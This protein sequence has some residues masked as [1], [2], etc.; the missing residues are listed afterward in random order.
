MSYEEE[1]QE[2]EANPLETEIDADPWGLGGLLPGVDSLGLEGDALLRQSARRRRV[3]SL[4]RVRP[5][6]VRDWLDEV[7][8]SGAVGGLSPLPFELVGQSRVSIGT[9][10]SVRLQAQAQV[11]LAGPWRLQLPPGLVVRELTFGHCSALVAPG[12]IP[13]E[14]FVESPGVSPHNCLAFDAPPLMLGCIASLFLENRGLAEVELSATLWGRTTWAVERADKRLLAQ[15]QR[16]LEKTRVETS[17]FE[18]RWLERRKRFTAE[19]QQLLGGLA[20]D[21]CPG[22]HSFAA[23][24]RFRELL[25]ELG[26]AELDAAEGAVT[27]SARALDVALD[28]FRE[29]LGSLSTRERELAEREASLRAREAES[30]PRE[31]V[32]VGP[33]SYELAREADRRAT[34]DYLRANPPA[35]APPVEPEPAWNECAWST[36]TDES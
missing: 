24:H 27:S 9:G 10:F 28:R 35:P 6:L 36:A 2:L 14:H 13:S 31:T 5:E 22:E 20:A 29:R 25:K 15:V 21:G 16:L 17:P 4:R 19:V 33:S 32:V 3:Q 11:P 26:A 34:E 1:L 12:A 30:P 7:A 23:L 8:D 18:S